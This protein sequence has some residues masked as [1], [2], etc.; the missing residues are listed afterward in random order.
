[1]KRVVRTKLEAYVCI[2]HIKLNQ[3]YS[4]FLLN[5]GKSTIKRQAKSV[6]FERHE[7]SIKTPTPLDLSTTETWN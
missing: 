6:I 4:G 1:M 5:K 3:T 2:H 7:R